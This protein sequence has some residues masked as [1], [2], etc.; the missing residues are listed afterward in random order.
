MKGEFSHDQ[1]FNMNISWLQRIDYLIHIFGIGLFEGDIK[2]MYNALMMLEIITSPK[3]DNDEVEANLEEI[4][5]NLSTYIL[6]DWRGQSTGYDSI[7]KHEVEQLCVKT[8]QQIM[9]KLEAKGIL[10]RG[11][12]DPT[13]AMGNFNC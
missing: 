4:N 9:I 8:L 3:L 12:A 1:E 7:K 10:T 11:K 6:V 2:A 13:K 5:K